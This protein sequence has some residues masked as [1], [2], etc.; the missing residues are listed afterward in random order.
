MFFIGLA[1]V[2][3]KVDY[4]GITKGCNCPVCGSQ[5]SLYISKQYNYFHI[6]FLPVKKFHIHYAAVCPECS[7]IFELSPEKGAQAEE[8]GVV[9]V[10][11]RDLSLVHARRNPYSE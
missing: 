7:S 4:C 10:S 5:A 2:Q 6:F 8:T 3:G 11:S 1:G 9:S